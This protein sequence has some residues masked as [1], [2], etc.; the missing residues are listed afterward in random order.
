MDPNVS[1]KVRSDAAHSLMT[2]LKQP[3]ATQVKVDISIKD[4]DTLVQLKEL[5]FNLAKQ[6]SKLIASGAINAREMAESTLLPGECKR[7]E[8]V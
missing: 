8:N 7:I 2:T 3:E 5:T 4:D 1:N 6:Q